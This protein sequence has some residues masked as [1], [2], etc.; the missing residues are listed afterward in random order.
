MPAPNSVSQKS[1]NSFFSQS[2][3]SMKSKKPQ[4]TLDSL[5]NKQK[6]TDT[7]KTEEDKDVEA[8][9]KPKERRSRIIEDDEDEITSTETTVATPPGKESDHTM[10]VDS[11]SN[12]STKRKSTSKSPPNSPPKKQIKLENSKPIETDVKMEDEEKPVSILE[13]EKEA[14]PAS[15]IKI[16]SH[17]N[18]LDYALL[19][20]TFE[21]IEATPQRLK[22][23]AFISELFLEVLR[24]KP[25]ELAKVVY[26]CINRLGP[27]Y[28]PGL[29]L[30]LGETLI[31]KALAE[32]TGRTNA[33][34]KNDYKEVGDLGLV[35]LKSRNNQ[36]TMF[37]P[38][39]LSVKS[40][41]EGLKDIAS[42][43]GKDS[44]TRKIRV[45]KRLLTSSKG[46]QAKFLVRSL[47]GKLRIGL[48]EKSVLTG[49]A[50]AFVAWEHEKSGSKAKVSP[51]VVT[52]AEETIREVYCQVPN[53]G[54]IIDAAI[55][56]G[57]ESV[58]ETC[59]LSA[60]IP[61]KPMLAKPTKSITEIL[62]RFSGEEF[63]CEY[64]YD[65]ERAQVHLTEDGQLRV[66]SRNME[67]MSQRYPDII[68]SIAQFSKKD[69]TKSYIIDCEA[70]A[71]DREQGKLL[72]FQVLS[73]RKRKDVEEDKIK[74]RICLFAFDLLYLNGES[75][76]KKPLKERRELLREH[77]IPAEGHFAFAQ[78]LNSNNVDDI[79]TFLDQ[80]V[81]DSCE[82]LM[83]KV[84]KGTESGYEPSK[85]S[86]NWLKLKKDYLSGVGDSLDLVVLGA[87]YG[88]GKR[89]SNYGAFLLGSYNSESETYETICKIGTGFSDE[90][91]DTI[92]KSLSPTVIEKPKG[93]YSYSSAS[94]AQPDVWFEPTMVWEVLTA[95]LSLSPIYQ[96]GIDILGKGVSL[97]FPRFIRIRDDKG[98]EDAT[99]SEQVVE[100]YRRQA[101]I[102]N[103]GGANS[104]E[105]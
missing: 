14:A 61:L 82:G 93:Y 86:R 27:E 44:Q 6:T 65:G 56:S 45:I 34:I 90:M 74:V 40:V 97:R 4:Q 18:S 101:S 11:P 60:G 58:S 41:F 32:A 5:F 55:A 54:V 22:I 48:A 51:E 53:Y 57:I 104:D 63:T 16:L 28:E 13:I 35:A 64:K 39:P 3:G 88:K 49:L 8:T 98:V 84:L 52:K 102:S 38:K 95:D 67:D 1:I 50:Q 71:W 19:V 72:P 80:S 76:L 81:K 78:S 47:E 33:Q 10:D 103:G 26:L 21:K 2:K 15:S 36:P 12:V 85:R 29:E 75:L 7:K 79:Q 94:Q 69:T 66:Y 83:I 46:V 96:A 23:V 24:V 31:I 89:T 9:Q 37:K 59:K 42:M 77:F 100:L 87:Y 62:D 43:S 73:T 105:D 25:E 92:Y 91:L 17:D 70:V 30:G 68:S 20:D 99:T